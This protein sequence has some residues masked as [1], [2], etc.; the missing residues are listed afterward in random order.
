MLTLS[1]LILFCFSSF[2][3]EERLDTLLK[4][5]AKESPALN[6]DNPND[7]SSI[8]EGENSI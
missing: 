1:V 2:I 8:S 6:A 7:S 3:A 5:L 4:S